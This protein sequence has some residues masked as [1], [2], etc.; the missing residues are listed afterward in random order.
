MAN[1]KSLKT[2][3]N[4][5]VKRNG[6]QEITGQILNSVLN[7]MV[8]TLGTGYSFAGVV[9]PSTNPGTPD[10][11]VFYLA[12]GK[13][14]YTNF[15]GIEVTEDEVVVLYWDSLWHKELTGIAREENLTN[16]EKEVATKQNALTDTDGGY[17]QRVAELEKEGIASNEKLTELDEKIYNTNPTIKEKGVYICNTE[18]DALLRLDILDTKSNIGSNLVSSIKSLVSAKLAEGVPMAEFDELGEK[19]SDIINKAIGD[20]SATIRDSVEDGFYIVNNKGEAI[21]TFIDGQWRFITPKKKGYYNKKGNLSTGDRWV[22]GSNSVKNNKRMVFSGTIS[23]FT[24]LTIGHGTANDYLGSWFDIDNTNV[25]LHWAKGANSAVF[26]HGLTIENNLQIEIWKEQSIDA[27]IKIVSNGVSKT[28]DI[29]S[30]EG[31]YYQGDQG[32]IYISATDCNLTDC[33]FSWTCSK[34]QNGLWLFGDSYFTLEAKDRWPYYL[35][36]DGFTN[37]MLNGYSGEGS[38]VAYNDF[39]NLLELSTPHIVVWCLG[40]NDG[41]TNTAINANWLDKYNKIKTICDGLG[42]E[43]VLATIPTSY[44]SEPVDGNDGKT[45]LQEY[46]NAFIKSTGLRY[47]DF[48]SAVGA[49]GQGNWYEGMKQTNNVHPTVKGAIALYQQAICDCPELMM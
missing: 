38:N 33:V 24:S 35:I 46:K 10:A 9:T 4:A 49:D 42:I 7:A 43:L 13:G 15:G 29:L 26:A 19:A 47:I 11:K 20:K 40:M 25:T 18:G 41:D 44:S 34:L 16:L 8:D 5:N 14:S 12:Y 36:Q 2:T 21:A 23:S 31:N 22:I 17:G 30:S 6:N 39:V 1:Y 48:A 28:I 45:S 37:W 3:I 27:K 32:E